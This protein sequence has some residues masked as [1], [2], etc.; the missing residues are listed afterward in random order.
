MDTYQQLKNRE[1]LKKIL[2]KTSLGKILKYFIIAWVVLD[3]IGSLTEIAFFN[4]LAIGLLF[5]VLPTVLYYKFS[6]P[7]PTGRHFSPEELSTSLSDLFLKS[8][9]YQDTKDV[10]KLAPPP[11]ALPHEHV[12]RKQAEKKTSFVGYGMILCFAYLLYVVFYQRETVVDAFA[13]FLSLVAG[14]P[15]PETDYQD[16]REFIH[17]DM[18]TPVL[19][20]STGIFSLTLYGVLT[21]VTSLFKPRNTDTVREL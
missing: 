20:V 18:A 1:E 8:P 19:V 12:V 2:D 10:E 3:I 13:W 4:T 17:S 21:L 9:K 15:L 5:V 7:T 16:L 14:M 6:K 11:E